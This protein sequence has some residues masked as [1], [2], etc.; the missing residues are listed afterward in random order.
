[1]SFLQKMAFVMGLTYTEKRN[2]K[3]KIKLRDY[4]V[5]KYGERFFA[6]FFFFF[7]KRKSEPYK[8][9]WLTYLFREF[10]NLFLHV[11]KLK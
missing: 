11:E 9:F 5:R 2:E 3:R 8:S 7:L 4:S 6:V 10:R 1:M